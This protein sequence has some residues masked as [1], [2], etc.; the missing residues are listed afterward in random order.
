MKIEGKKGG[1][2]G[3]KEEDKNLLKNE[4]NPRFF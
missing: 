2:S 3:K 1:G 4:A